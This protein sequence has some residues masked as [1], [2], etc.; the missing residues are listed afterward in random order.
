MDLPSPITDLQYSLKRKTKLG[1][2]VFSKECLML[3]D[4]IKYI[5]RE[6]VLDCYSLFQNK[7][8]DKNWMKKQFDR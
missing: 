8:G 5:D 3:I 4:G 7:Y 6:L 1:K 2:E